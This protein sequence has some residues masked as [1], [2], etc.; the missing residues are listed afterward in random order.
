MADDRKKEDM[1]PRLEFVS[2]YVS[3]TFRIKGDKWQKLMMSDDKVT[4]TDPLFPLDT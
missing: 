1:D 2:S 4:K 3:K